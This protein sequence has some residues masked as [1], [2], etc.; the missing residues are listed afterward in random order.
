MHRD[1][2]RDIHFHLILCA[3]CTLIDQPC[4]E[5][6]GKGLLSIEYQIPAFLLIQSIPS[7]QSVDAKYIKAFLLYN[8]NK[9][10]IPR[11]LRNENITCLSFL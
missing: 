7:G 8:V 1:Q 6:N 11:V 4:N 2:N 3:S 10:T 9:P 5:A